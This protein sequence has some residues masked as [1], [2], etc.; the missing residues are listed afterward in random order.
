MLCDWRN[1]LKDV[2]N[3][4]KLSFP[5][6]YSTALYR[7]PFSFATFIQMCALHKDWKTFICEWQNENENGDLNLSWPNKVSY[8]FNLPLCS[9]HLENINLCLTWYTLDQGYQTYSLSY[10]PIQ[11]AWEEV[12]WCVLTCLKINN[13]QNNC[14]SA[15]QYWQLHLHGILLLNWTMV[16]HGTADRQERKARCM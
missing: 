1:T 13:G 7:F 11:K 15:T 10:G 14:I 4:W 16:H 2:K 12:C 8:S 6:F 3:Q 9:I 5:F